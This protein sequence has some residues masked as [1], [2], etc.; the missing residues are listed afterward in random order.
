[1][2]SP[3]IME[4]ARRL[5]D[6]LRLPVEHH[7]EGG[8]K[9]VRAALTLLS[10]GAAGAEESV[11]IVGA[12][13]IE[14]I[15]NFSLVHDDVIDRDEERRHRA[16]VWSKFGIGP[17]VVAGDALALLA[18]QILLENPTAERVRATAL[19]A[20]ST[21]AMIAGQSEDMA[22]ENRSSVTVAECLAMEAGKTAALLS[23]AASLG[24]VL[25]G[26]AESV[27]VTLGD[28][29]RH[30]GLAF[31]AVDDVLGI[32]GE[33]AATGKPVGS[34]LLSHK[35]TLPIALALAHGGP[36]RDELVAILDGPLSPAEVARASAWL[37]EQGA[38]QEA[39]DM[40]AGHLDAAL[41]A[42]GQVSLAP[43]PAAELAQIARYVVARDQ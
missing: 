19:L 14:L 16:T 37:E 32:W 38:R 5:N 12:V 36:I 7:L 11:G 3:A 10:A 23:C 21:Q 35:K 41:G 13:A 17:A 30:L 43:G 40:A 15:H 22:F 4:A 42:L 1:M 29:G 24:A 31:Q 33:S 20:D 34:D 39:M 8:G 25:A 28:F 6:Q 9:R 26:A 18:V 27:V 2:V